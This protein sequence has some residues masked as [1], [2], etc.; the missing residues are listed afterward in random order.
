MD[1]LK[2]LDFSCHRILGAVSWDFHIGQGSTELSP[3]VRMDRSASESHR[4][5]MFLMAFVLSKV[6][7]HHLFDRNPF[8]QSQTGQMQATYQLQGRH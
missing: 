5:E 2:G 3:E 1:Q 4:Q 8:C 7:F 6:I